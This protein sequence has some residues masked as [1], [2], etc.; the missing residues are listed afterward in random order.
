MLPFLSLLLACHHAPAPAA[1]PVLL[2]DCLI[3]PDTPW[4]DELAEL[5]AVPEP[6][7]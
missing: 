3:G 1:A 5:C 7:T 2:E 4:R 6:G